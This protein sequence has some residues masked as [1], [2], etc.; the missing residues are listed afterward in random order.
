MKRKCQLSNF[1]KGFLMSVL[2]CSGTTN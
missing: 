2:F 1:E